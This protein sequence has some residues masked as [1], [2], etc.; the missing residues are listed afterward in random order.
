MTQKYPDGKVV[1]SPGTVIITAVAEVSDVK[2]VIS[3]VLLSKPGSVLIYIPF[4]EPYFELGGSSFAQVLN[5]LGDR[6]PSVKEAPYFIKA[7]TVIQE[8]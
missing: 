4:S 8:L 6:T 1:Y 3:P 7:F 2:K 5:S